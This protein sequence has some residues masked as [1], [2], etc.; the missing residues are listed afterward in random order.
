MGEKVGSIPTPAICILH[1]GMKTFAKWLEAYLPSL[2]KVQV[3]QHNGE[4]E[5][6][7]SIGKVIDELA[8]YPSNLHCMAVTIDHGKKQTGVWNKIA[9]N[10]VVKVD[11]GSG[12]M[13]VQG[14]IAQVIM[15]LKRYPI[16][17]G[18]IVDVRLS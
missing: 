8:G 5:L 14:T 6:T 11:Q 10:P 16:D 1:T 13:E 4:I 9:S 18:V 15:R 17:H 3:S 12:N 7:G 2:D